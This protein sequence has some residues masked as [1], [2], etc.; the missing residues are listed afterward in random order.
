MIIIII[1]LKEKSVIYTRKT[2][3]RF[4]KADSCTWNITRNTESVIVWN[5]SVS[6]GGTGGS[7]EVPGRKGL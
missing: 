3:D 1:K 5:W 6:G 2:F 4:T 7:R